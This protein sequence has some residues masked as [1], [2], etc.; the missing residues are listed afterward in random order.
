MFLVYVM[1]TFLYYHYIKYMVYREARA[2]G[3]ET[4]KQNEI[5]I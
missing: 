1:K 4:K 3:K 5:D 2:K